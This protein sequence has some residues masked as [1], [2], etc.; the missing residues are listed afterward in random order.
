MKSLE[1]L[2]AL[3]ICREAAIMDRP[4]DGK[5][6]KRQREQILNAVAQLQR[7]EDHLTN[8]AIAR[9]V[10]CSRATWTQIKGGCYSGNVDLYLI[11]AQKWMAERESRTA[12]PSTPYVKTSI[13]QLILTVCRRAWEVPC[14]GKIITPSGAGKTAALHEFCR[15]AGDRA[16]Y[17]AA[18]EIFK[19]KYGLIQELA[20]ALGMQV[21]ANTK[22][23]VL[24]RRI[25]EELARFYAG[26]EQNP[27]CVI[28]DEA[29]TLSPP[30]LNVLR[31]LHDDPACRVGI[32]LADT[33]RLAAELHSRAGIAGG[34]EQLRSRMGAQYI[35]GDKDEIRRADVRAVADSVLDALGHTRQLDRHSYEYLHELAQMDGKLRNV[36]HRLHAA[37][38]VMAAAGREPSY[39]T[40]EI[41]Y[42]ADLVGHER[43]LDVVPPAIQ[44]AARKA[45]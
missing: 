15:V 44:A 31:N 41:D 19:T 36:V 18:G 16:I 24:Y 33:A 32:V 21:M 35:L 26:G 37:H 6:T 12:A 38:H 20:E 5:L 43:K 39:S 30:A 25:R 7:R 17:L 42:V 1:N 10:R 34:Y 45:S 27:L 3:E 4:T 11:R 14:I 9:I 13:G 2:T 22:S 23:A 29:T 40:A 8:T 28:V